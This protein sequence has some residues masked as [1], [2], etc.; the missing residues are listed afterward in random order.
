MHDVAVERGKVLVAVQDVEQIGAHRHQFAGA[1]GRAVEP[2]DQLLPP[3]L[4]G[5]MQVA[6]VVVARLRAPGLDRL[7]KLFAVGPVIPRQRREE[8]QPPVLVE[9]VVA[10]EHVARHRGARGFAAARQQRLA[11]FDQAGG[12][13]LVVGGP[14][15]PQQRAA[16]LGDRRQ[17]VGE[18]G[19]GHV[20]G[21]NPI[22]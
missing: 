5:E 14:A 10:V 4:G 3:R 13:L 18:K 20:G 7:R 2:A 22:W 15:A 21:S 12:V 9:V 19:V 6:G 8:R 1:A 16:P 11:Q 17:Q